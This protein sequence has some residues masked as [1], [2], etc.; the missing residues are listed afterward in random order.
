MART[1]CDI[2]VSGMASVYALSTGM[3]KYIGDGC[4]TISGE[5]LYGRPD[6]AIYKAGADAN[7]VYGSSDVLKD[8]G[9]SW[10]DEYDSPDECN[11]IHAVFWH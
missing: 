5:T 11:C 10:A 2:A 8:A 6:D 4:L 3:Y 7:G 9:N 1:Q